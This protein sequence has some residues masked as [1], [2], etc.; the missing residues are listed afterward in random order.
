[1]RKH[2]P[3]KGTRLIDP[4]KIGGKAGNVQTSRLGR[5]RVGKTGMAR[6]AMRGGKAGR[7]SRHLY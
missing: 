4:D 6:K 1:M 2:K 7:V 5:A 3:P